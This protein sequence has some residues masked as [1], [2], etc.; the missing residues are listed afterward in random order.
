VNICKT[1]KTAKD[2]PSRENPSTTSQLRLIT[3]VTQVN[4]PTKQE[5]RTLARTF[6]IYTTAKQEIHSPR[7]ESSPSEERGYVA[8][9]RSNWPA[10][11]SEPLPANSLATLPT[12]CEKVA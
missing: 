4:S 2:A 5:L 12:R 10:R 11:P 9:H 8:I 3:E 1:G 7:G 6:G